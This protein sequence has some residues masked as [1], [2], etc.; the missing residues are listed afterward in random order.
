MLTTSDPS[1]TSDEPTGAHGREGSI[2]ILFLLVPPAHVAAAVIFCVL[3]DH[4]LSLPDPYNNPFTNWSTGFFLFAGALWVL[5]GF[6]TIFRIRSGRLVPK[7]VVAW[8]ILA[9]L[10][11]ALF[12]IQMFRFVFP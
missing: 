11:S 10:P 1:N 12:I 4:Q 3:R 8:L 2:P 7:L 9:T 6:W 5:G